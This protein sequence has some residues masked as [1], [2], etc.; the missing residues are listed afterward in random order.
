MSKKMQGL[1]V[2]PCYSNIFATQEDLESAAKK[3]A[4]IYGAYFQKDS[5]ANKNALPAIFLQGD[6]GSGKTTFTR[7]FVLELPGAEHA[8]VSSPSFTLCNNYATEPP[9]LHCDLY[10]CGSVLP[11]DL[12]DGLEEAG[13][14]CIVEW[15]E[16]LPAEI[17]GENARQDYLYIH[18]KICEEGR[19]M[20]IV[21]QGALSTQF[22]Q[23]WQDCK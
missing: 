2:K 18:L 6:L 11:D 9:I 1:S 13:K 17:C 4:H 19:L 5:L 16:Y 7:S 21:A 15:A 8:E 14:L 3:L 20:N 12:W 10:R 22:M 23:L